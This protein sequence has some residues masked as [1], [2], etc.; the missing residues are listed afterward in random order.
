MNNFSSFLNYGFISNGDDIGDQVTLLLQLDPKDPLYDEKRRM[1]GDEDSRTLIVTAN[2][3]QV[4][5][6]KLVAFARLIVLK[7]EDARIASEEIAAP[8]LQAINIIIKE[9]FCKI[10]EC[11]PSKIDA[12]VERLSALMIGLHRQDIIQ[13]CNEGAVN[14]TRLACLIGAVKSISNDGSCSSSSGRNALV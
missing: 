12:Q 7:D 10:K 4:K 9:N 2:L 11:V 6:A 13:I 1:L 14:Q 5:S 3:L 8:T